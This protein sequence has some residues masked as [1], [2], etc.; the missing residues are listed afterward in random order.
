MLAHGIGGGNEFLASHRRRFRYPH[1]EVASMELRSSSCSRSSRSR[2]SS[3]SLLGRRAIPAPPRGPPHPVVHDRGRGTALGSPWLACP[4]PGGTDPVGAS[5]R[6]PCRSMASPVPRPSAGR[7][8]VPQTPLRDR[9]T[10]VLGPEK[11]DASGDARSAGRRDEEVPRVRDGTPR[12]RD[13]VPGVRI[14]GIG[15]RSPRERGDPSSFPR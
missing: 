5:G 10:G 7:R 2:R 14:R 8:R 9:S 13:D 6:E 12:G 4:A 15:D 3:S 1:Q 11:S